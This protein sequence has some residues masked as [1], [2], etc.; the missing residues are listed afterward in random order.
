[1]RRINYL[2]LICA[3]VFIFNTS[4]TKDNS[5]PEPSAPKEPTSAFTK[6]NNTKDSLFTVN[7]IVQL[8][9][10]SYAIAGGIRYDGSFDRNVLIKLNKFGKREWMSIMKNTSTPR[11]IEELFADVNGYVGIRTQSFGNES[12]RAPHMVKFSSTGEVLSEVS[13]DT[14][15]VGL[16]IIKDNN[17]F[18]IAGRGNSDMLFRK[19][20]MNGEKQWDQTFWNY[21]SACSISKL[22]DGNYI[23]IGGWFYSGNDEYLIKLNA[24]GKKLWS[25]LY[26]GIK[27]V[28]L[29]DNGFLAVT[30]RAGVSTAPK[31]VRFDEHGNELWNKTLDQLW[32][33]SEL[34]AI[35]VMNYDMKHFICTYFDQI[36]NVTIMVLDAN[37]NE[38]KRLTK[39]S[40]YSAAYAQRSF[41]TIK[42]L[43]NGIFIALAGVSN[44]LEFFLDFIKVSPKSI[45]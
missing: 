5:A 4:C 15:F 3:I 17:N 11:G 12:G 22:N 40:V 35:N 13:I 30:G 29:P 32:P 10:S 39:G 19:I 41:V 38:V 8:S 28:A 23:A 24:G 36:G 21:P 6:Y 33:I 14:D 26:K 1:M 20:G 16:D 45:F 27:V 34:K 7:S 31:L 25:K 9:D 18:V 37:G 42:T 2:Q 43:D 44:N